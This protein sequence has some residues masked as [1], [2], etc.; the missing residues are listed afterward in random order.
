MWT[1]NSTPRMKDM[2]KPFFHKGTAKK[3]RLLDVIFTG[4]SFPDTSKPASSKSLTAKIT[5]SSR[6]EIKTFFKGRVRVPE[7]LDF[8]WNESSSPAKY[9]PELV[10]D[11]PLYWGLYFKVAEEHDSNYYVNKDDPSKSGLWARNNPS[12]GVVSVQTLVTTILMC[13]KSAG[14]TFEEL[15]SYLVVGKDNNYIWAL[16]M[17][18]VYNNKSEVR[19]GNHLTEN[20][21]KF[22][23]S[24]MKLTPNSFYTGYP[25]RLKVVEKKGAKE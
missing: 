25:D 9:Y 1:G 12:K 10:E 18:W 2:I 5:P 4:S 17:Q 16:T 7:T 23:Y 13:A 19:L 3:S 21:A 20:A 14:F 8:I 24:T 11:S 6:E 15:M 22:I